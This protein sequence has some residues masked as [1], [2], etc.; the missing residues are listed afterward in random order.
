MGKEKNTFMKRRLLLTCMEVEKN[1]LENV[2]I[3]YIWTTF[4]INYKFQ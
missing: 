3:L 2:A 4:E 1:I